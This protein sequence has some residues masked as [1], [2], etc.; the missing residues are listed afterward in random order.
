MR[1][2]FASPAALVLCVAAVVF[3][4]TASAVSA[5]VTKS[6]SESAVIPL[7]IEDA[8]MVSSFQIQGTAPTFS[9]DGRWVS[10]TVCDPIKIKVEK[11]G[12]RN[13]STPDAAYRSLGCDI[14]VSPVAG[15]PGRILTADHGNNWSPTWSPDDAW[16]AFYSDRDGQPNLWLWNRRL[17]TFRKVSDAPTRNWLA[18][19]APLWT[20][21]SRQLVFKL[22]PEG[23]D[24]NLIHDQAVQ[25]RDG[26][27]VEVFESPKPLLKS[28][29]P[30]LADAPKP[31]DLAVVDIASGAL[32]RLVSDANSA[33]YTLSPDG[34]YVLNVARQPA[35]PE[36][37]MQLQLIELASGKKRTLIKDVVE[38]YPGAVSWSPD[39]RQLAYTAVDVPARAAR[40]KAAST[41]SLWH[42]A[43]DLFIM[44]VDTGKT[45]KVSGAPVNN[46]GVRYL[47]PLW[48]AQGRYI[49]LLSADHQ[50]WKV[51]VDA[52]RAQAL[53]Q[54]IGRE[55]LVLVADAAGNTVGST[56]GRFIYA[57]TRSPTNQRQ[58]FSRIDML[59]GEATQMLE[60]D[61]VI[62]QTFMPPALSADHRRLLYRAESSRRSADL[63]ISGLDFRQPHLLTTLNPQLDRYKF[64][65]SQVINFNS[66]D[67]VPLKASVLLPADYQPGKRCPTLLWVYAGDSDTQQW[68]NNFGLVPINAFNMQ[69]FATRGYAVIWPE[70]P[71]HE[72]T[73]I[74]DLMKSVM[75]AIDRLVDLGIADSER[76]AVMGNSNGGYS[77]LALITQTKRF[78]VAV[79]NSGFGDLA[80]VYGAMGGRWIPW[81]ERL[82]G[83]MQAPPWEV[84]LRYVENSPV[85]FLDRVATPL[86]MEAGAADLGII[87]YSDE[88]WVDLQH[89][90]KEVLYLRYGGE[91]H[92]LS[93]AAN[94]KDYWQRVFAFFDRHL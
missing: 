12:D 19:E 22:R 57:C 84:P 87:N 74:A 55:K 16:L 72:G 30:P 58:G 38:E 66:A 54:D 45:E 79:M 15:G 51:D 9:P 90:N 64:G 59:T 61:Q 14:W 13:I 43:G 52:R 83:S 89:L 65:R 80:A 73:P 56:D 48:D 24:K 68:V 4:E 11:E 47:P 2:S 27:T 53:T 94:L 49:Y 20:P 44:S 42:D 37:G 46:F 10:S 93:A 69:M 8:A 23:S 75:P 41:T 92:V 85:Y 78:K 5:V 1:S 35:D 62:C 25:G 36:F 82:G 3:S 6:A 40:L 34:R 70:I 39:S 18:Y 21:D 28:G 7:R 77:A 71:T 67:G 76:L 29:N 88:V 32:R 81:L 26:S 86:I 63:W 31:T 50:V 33:I 60:E 17:D 91:G